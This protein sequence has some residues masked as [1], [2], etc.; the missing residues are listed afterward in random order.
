MKKENIKAG[1]IKKNVDFFILIE[2]FLILLKT[3]IR[4]NF[5]KLIVMGFTFLK[6]P[7]YNF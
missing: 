6:P 3:K 2:L 4:G 7:G 5:L 1:T